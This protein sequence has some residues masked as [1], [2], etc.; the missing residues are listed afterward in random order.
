MSQEQEGQTEAEVGGVEEEQV[1]LPTL[2]EF[3]AWEYPDNSYLEEPGFS[4]L[5]VRKGGIFVILDSVFYRCENV[6]TIASVTAEEPGNG[7]F[8]RFIGRLE[9]KGLAVFVENS[10]NERLRDKLLDL[11]FTRVDGNNGLDFLYNH[12]E[13]ICAVEF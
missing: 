12:D 6:L 1:K 5:Y 11:G 7:T 10:H 13:H 3:L 9:E 4:S 8:T 2:D